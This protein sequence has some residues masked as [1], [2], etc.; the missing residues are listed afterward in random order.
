MPE[1]DYEAE[2]RAAA[3]KSLELVRDGMRLGL[4]SGTT[5]RIMVQLLAERVAA[6][7]NIIAVPTSESTARLADELGIP[8][9]SLLESPRLDL[10]IDGA[11]EIDP[12]LNLI[13]GGGGALLREKV[14]ASVSSCMVVIADSSKLAPSLGGFPLPVEVAKFCYKSIALQIEDLGGAAVL[15]HT[16]AGAPFRTDEDN[17]ILDCDF[18]K[19]DNLCALAPR[20]S[21]MPGVMEHGLFVGMA[22]AAIIGRG[23]EVEILG[24]ADL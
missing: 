4:G 15:R 10:T 17:F 6:G 5:S 20:L 23:N 21:A 7:L 18:S 19:V 8:L 14:A 13:K 24:R 22:Q 12:D 2:K 3:A 11:D 16:S 1:V 9:V